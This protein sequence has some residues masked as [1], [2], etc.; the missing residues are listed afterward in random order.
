MSFDRLRMGESSSGL[1]Y[2]D[3]RERSLVRVAQTHGLRTVNYGQTSVTRLRRAKCGCRAC[4][5]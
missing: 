3:L 5:A 1:D 4:P 2:A